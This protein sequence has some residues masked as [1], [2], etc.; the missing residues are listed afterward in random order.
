MVKLEG[1]LMALETEPSYDCVKE[2]TCI[3]DAGMDAFEIAL[4]SM[5]TSTV[6]L[7]ADM[8]TSR[9]I[10][11]DK[12]NARRSV[13]FADPPVTQLWEVPRIDKNSR[14]SMFYS[15]RDIVK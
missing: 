3:Y 4:N 12:T 10:L 2:M 6:A 8:N 9:W 13:S 1:D 15:K 14:R 5:D 11:G 7:L